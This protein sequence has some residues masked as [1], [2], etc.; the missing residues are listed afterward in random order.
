MNFNYKWISMDN[1]KVLIE[2]INELKENI[3]DDLIST[4]Q[5][6]TSL[7]DFENR[8]KVLPLAQFGEKSTALKSLLILFNITNFSD[9]SILFYNNNSDLSVIEEAGNRSLCRKIEE[10]I[11]DDPLFYKWIEK[12][13]FGGLYFR[14]FAESMIKE[15]S[16]Y[17]LISLTSSRNFRSTRFHVLCDIIMDYLKSIGETKKGIYN[18]LFDYTII[19]LTKFISLFEDNEPAV[20]FFR[21]EYISE[22]FNKIGIAA[23]IEMSH[24]IK[25]KLIELF[26]NSISVIRLSLSNY[27]VVA[28]R[29]EGGADFGAMITRNRINFSYKGIL[30]PYT[31]VEVPYKKENSIYD[32][33]ENVNLLNNYLCDGD[34]RI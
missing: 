11:K 34:I 25:Q 4:E 2:Q 3:I 20:F 16:V 24:Y 22:F 7:N 12:I 6:I 28:P 30:L 31:V 29:N 23:I 19:E 18:D 10:F 13:E 32:I 21:Y 27:V 33:F 9:V 14:L 17:T 1:V 26:G 15:N 8:Y 5:A